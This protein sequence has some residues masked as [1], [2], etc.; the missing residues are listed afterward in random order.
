MANQ[1]RTIALAQLIAHPDNPNRMSKANFNKLV[2][3]IERTGLYEPIIVRRHPEMDGCFEI[4]NGHH[5]CNALAQLGC[6]KA[7][8][9][10]WDVNDEQTGILLATLNRLG[11]SDKLEKKLLLLKKLTTINELAKLGKL[12][13]YSAKQIDRLCGLKLPSKPVETG[14]LRSLAEP[15][16]FFLS[17][18][19]RQIVENAL[20]LAEP[21]GVKT[22]KAV[23]NTNALVNIAQHYIKGYKK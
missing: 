14:S 11:G 4:I 13:P 21:A 10:V 18:T 15:M 1:I 12:L 5:R 16:V 20:A 9:V 6:E 23:K 8:C 17:D 7:D 22:P 3:N 2:R 19:Q